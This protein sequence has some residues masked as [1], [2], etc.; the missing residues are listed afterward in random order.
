[1]FRHCRQINP[2]IISMIVCQ[3]NFQGRVVSLADT[4]KALLPGS[5]RFTLIMLLRLPV[6]CE[7]FIR[8]ICG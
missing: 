6:L 2:A 1:M 5:S 7:D 8:L 3:S 4:L